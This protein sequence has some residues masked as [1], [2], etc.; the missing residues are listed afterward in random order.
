MQMRLKNYM[1][2]NMINE[3]NFQIK[4]VTPK[5]FQFENF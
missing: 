3:K 1:Q 5:Y 2:T 4:I